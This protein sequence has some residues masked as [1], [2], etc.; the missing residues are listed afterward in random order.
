M[1]MVSALIINSNLPISFW[2][3]ALYTACHI[4]NRVLHKGYDKTPY[5]LF[6]GRKPNLQNLKCGGVLHM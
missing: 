6:K 5:E 2:G 1:E 4:G 3:K